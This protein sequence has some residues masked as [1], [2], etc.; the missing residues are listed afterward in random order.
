MSLRFSEK[1]ESSSSTSWLHEAAEGQRIHEIISAREF[2]MGI[3]V[4]VYNFLP[5]AQ[6]P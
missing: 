1:C 5:A 6:N 3:C 2:V 4:C